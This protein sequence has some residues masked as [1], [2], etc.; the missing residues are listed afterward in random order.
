[1]GEQLRKLTN[2]CFLACR[3]P[4]NLNATFSEKEEVCVSKCEG[5]VEKI[6][7]VVER[8]VNDTFT[9]QFF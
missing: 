8:H 3:D 6:K 9:P 5:R 1:M 2:D 7:A 4:S